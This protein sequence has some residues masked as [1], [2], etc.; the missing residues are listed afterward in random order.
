MNKV[1]PSVRMKEEVERVLCGGNVED[2][3]AEAPMQGFVRAL[4]RYHPAGLDRR[5]SHDLSRAWALSSR[6]ASASRVAEWLRSEAPANRG[7]AA[8]VSRAAAARHPGTV[9][10]ALVERLGTRTPDLEAL[11]SGMYARG[12]STQ[13]VSDLY[14]EELGR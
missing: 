8:G 5:G 9:S 3:A 11:V 13:D 2:A 4:A 10:P 6:R 1:P 7:R 12:L 14:G